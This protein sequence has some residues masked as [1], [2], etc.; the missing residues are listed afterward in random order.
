[1]GFAENNKNTKYHQTYPSRGVDS[2]YRKQGNREG[3]TK[4]TETEGRKIGGEKKED[5]AEKQR[6]NKREVWVTKHVINTVLNIAGINITPCS[7]KIS[8]CNS[9]PSIPQLPTDITTLHQRAI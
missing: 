4:E 2:A 1:M 8:P 3:R 9:W 7:I 5:E 6:K